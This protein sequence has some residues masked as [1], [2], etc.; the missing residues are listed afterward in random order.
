MK[1]VLLKSYYKSE[2]FLEIFFL[3]FYLFIFLD[4]SK[5]TRNLKN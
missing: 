3:K 2:E 4:K 1:L 5:D